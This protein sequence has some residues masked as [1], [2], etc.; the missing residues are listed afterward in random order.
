MVRSIIIAALLCLFSFGANAQI[1]SARLT[2]SG[3]T[4]SMCSKAIYKNL[5][6]LS[7][8]QKVDVDVETSTY[9]I[10]FKPGAAV[11]PDAVKKSVEDAGFAVA[12]LQVTASFPRMEVSAATPI[13]YAGAHYRILNATG[14]QVLEGER[15]F[16]VVDKGFLSPGEWKKYAALAGAK[17]AVAGR[18]YNVTL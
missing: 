11:S 3:L 10:T 7:I 6:K 4:C 5:Q 18:V 16:T 8:V 14:G 15:T 13:P 9:I 2:A 17:A 12:S 1:K